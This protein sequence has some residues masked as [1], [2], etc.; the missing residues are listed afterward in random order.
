MRQ[1]FINLFR[2]LLIRDTTDTFVFF[3]FPHNVPEL[4]KLGTDHWQADAVFL[5]NIGQIRRH[6]ADLDVYFSPI[7]GLQPL[8]L[9]PIPT[10][11][12]LADTQ[13][14]YYPQFFTPQDLF[15]RDWYL[16]VSSHLAD[17]VIAISQFSKQTIAHHYRL[18]PDRLVVAYPCADERYYRSAEV[19]K[20][21]SHPL[22]ETFI[23][24]PANRWQHK[25][26]DG[27]LRAMQ[28]LKEHEGLSINAVFT[29]NDVNGG[30]QLNEMA[31]RY[32]VG[33]LVHQIGFVSVEEMAYL[34][35]RARLLI[36]PSLF[37]GFGIPLVEAMAVGCPIAAANRTSLPEVAGEA[38][39]Y[40][41]PTTPDEIARAIKRLWFDAT[42]RTRLIDS[43]YRQARKFSVDQTVQAHQ[44]AFAQAARAYSSRRYWWNL[45]VYQPYHLLRVGL[46][47]VLGV[48]TRQV[49][50]ARKQSLW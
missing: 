29:G 6:L 9:P 17:R 33:D 45:T 26:H 24:Y 28:L 23:L 31:A 11:I 49:A 5:Q 25:N 46:K 13:D 32:G 44:E 42:L 38:A 30:Y 2:E 43:G 1:Y 40:F 48:Y 15:Y 50:F 37:E 8:P 39:L 34:Y 7:N 19:A 21:P 35:R 16:R 12:T 36:F 22:P 27:L 18:R 14:L 10:V 3:Y 41:D 20:A 4:A 47:R